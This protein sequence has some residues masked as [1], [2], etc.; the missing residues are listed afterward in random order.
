[1]TSRI[2]VHVVATAKTVSIPI[3]VVGSRHH[4]AGKN[5]RK[6]KKLAEEVQAPRTAVSNIARWPHPYDTAKQIM[7]SPE[8]HVLVVQNKEDKDQEVLDEFRGVHPAEGEQGWWDKTLPFSRE[9]ASQ[10]P[11]EAEAASP[12]Q[13][14]EREKR[15][16]S[17]S[18]PPFSAPS[19]KKVPKSVLGSAQHRVVAALL[20][21]SK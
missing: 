20:R 2:F 11:Q 17:T 16:R 6:V 4:M 8:A 19:G 1:M 10:P 3:T 18:P 7:E 9:V 5:H 12:P 15:K 14:S 13:R 21:G